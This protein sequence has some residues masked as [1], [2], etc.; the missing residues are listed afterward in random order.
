MILI[1]VSDA[2]QVDAKMEPVTVFAVH[3]YEYPVVADATRMVFWRCTISIPQ[4]IF[5]IDTG[6]FHW[7][8]GID[9]LL[10]NS[11]SLATEWHLTYAYFKRSIQRT[12][13]SVLNDRIIGVDS[14]IGRNTFPNEKIIFRAL[15]KWK[16]F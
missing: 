10:K 11:V 5:N 9:L 14:L 16:T 7:S 3:I 8:V 2:E 12:R 6:D 1:L 4:L 15:L 13:P